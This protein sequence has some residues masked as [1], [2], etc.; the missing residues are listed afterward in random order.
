M[1]AALNKPIADNGNISP[2]ER[3]RIPK[4]AH[5]RHA[6]K[7][8]ANALQTVTDNTVR[9]R[10]ARAEDEALLAEI[11]ITQLENRISE[12]IRERRHV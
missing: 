2:I 4:R 6:V 7:M 11:R 12:M 9:E 3:A 5:V 10:L 1:V 8:L